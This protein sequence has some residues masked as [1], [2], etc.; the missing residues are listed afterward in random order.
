M[1]TLSV[2]GQKIDLTPAFTPL[3]D[4]FEA[5][6]N[7]Y[8]GK[9]Y[10]KCLSF[11]N[12]SQTAQD[13]AQDIFV[14][15]F[16]KMSSFQNR[17]SFST[18]LYSVA[19]NYCIDQ[20]R[21]RNRLYIQPFVDEIVTIADEQDQST[22]IEARLQILEIVKKTLSVDE[23]YLLE[24]KY[25]QNRSSIAIAHHFNLTESAA[26]MRLKRLIDKLYRLCQSQEAD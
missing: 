12:D 15:V 22:L 23:I 25:V 18:W 3:P 26:K 7:R 24:L 8:I 10:Q 11:T 14:K 13:Y 4:T 5:L 1:K 20:G 21:T 9:V 19:H 6:Y 16:D 2:S 17:S